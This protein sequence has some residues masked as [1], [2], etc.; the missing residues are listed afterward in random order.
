MNVATL[1][2]GFISRVLSAPKANPAAASNARREERRKVLAE[3][4]RAKGEEPRRLKAAGVALEKANDA[5]RIAK[6]RYDAAAAAQQRADA[7]HTDAATS[8]RV[9]RLEQRRRDLACPE[10]GGL[11]E[12]ARQAR[13]DVRVGRK[14]CPW[15]PAKL[16]E[17]LDEAR[18]ARRWAI[19]AANADHDDEEVREMDRKIR[20]HLG[21][22]G[23]AR[24]LTPAELK[25]IRTDA[26]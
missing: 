5:L 25:A 18:I 7:E 17:W 21:L 16:D 9:A 20:D 19:D 4:E 3:L 2:P 13:T 10:L 22:D 23:V 12:Q 8:N 1:V 24:R 6:Q 14:P 26:E 15:G 11:A